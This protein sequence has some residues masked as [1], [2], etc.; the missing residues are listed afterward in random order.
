M[1]LET[2][3]LILR[4]WE[5][6]DAARLYELASSPDVGPIAGWRPHSSAE[7][8]LRVIRKVFCAPDTFAI[9]AKEEGAP[10]G[11]INIMNDDNSN[12]E[13]DADEGE[14]GFWLGVPYWGRGY[15]SEALKEVL[16]CG[17]EEKGLSRIWCAYFEG[18]VR[19]K[20]VQEK[21]GFRLH[22]TNRDMFWLPLG[23]VRTMHVC[24]ME[25][26]DWLAATQ[27]G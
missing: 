14:I 24:R 19:S 5:E 6:D 10:C 27:R 23:D 11:C 25:K 4:P 9:I 7:D 1:I 2:E 16:R 13:L 8:S 3:R 15:M 20:R 17:F 22:H 12:I 21:C 18:N 26:A